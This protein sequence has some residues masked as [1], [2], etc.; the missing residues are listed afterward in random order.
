MKIP[1]FFIVGAPKC[2]TT[3]LSD[4][5]RTHPE[6]FMSDPKEP[7]YFCDDFQHRAIDSFDRYMACFEGVSKS[8]KAV[9]E[10]SVWYLYSKVA[11]RNICDYNPDARIIVMLRNP[12]DLVYSLHSQLVYNHSEDV[13]DFQRAWAMQKDRRKGKNLPRYKRNTEFL[14]YGDVGMLGKQV[15]RLFSIFPKKQVSVVLFDEFSRATKRVYGNVLSFLG[16]VSD[17]R[18]D[19]QKV[20]SNK[21][22]RLKCLSSFTQR[23]PRSLNK[24]V[25]R[26]KNV[27]R[28]DRLKL[29][30]ALRNLNADHFVRKPMDPS[31]RK[32]L[33]EFFCDDVD[34]LSRLVNT[35]LNS[36]KCVSDNRVW[37]G[38]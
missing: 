21:G 27:F 31:F 35:D 14:Q 12:V 17:G 37:A 2:G 23:P 18:N 6:V 11:I 16:L 34:H 26:T 32:E 1:N 19:F 29:L 24:V 8:H 28:I 7:Y 20:N 38:R 33:V 4:Y 36:W 15:E 22:H 3:A 5:L 30:P 9:G 13:S 10:A 25:Q